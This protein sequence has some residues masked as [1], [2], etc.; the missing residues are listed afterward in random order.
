MS[1]SKALKDDF[2]VK[3]GVTG[4]ILSDT[5]QPLFVFQQVKHKRSKKLP[6]T[7]NLNS[8]TAPGEREK[9]LTQLRQ[10]SMDVHKGV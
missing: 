7:I 1:R 8:Q 6:A 4:A 3:C 9:A 10:V 2:N 5:V